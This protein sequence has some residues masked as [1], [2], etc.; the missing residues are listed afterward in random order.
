VGSWSPAAW[1]GWVRV[2]F[3][4]IVAQVID[5]NGAGI[6]PSSHPRQITTEIIQGGADLVE[7]RADLAADL[8]IRVVSKNF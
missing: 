4:R 1:S 8:L 6:T 3:D 2:G 5:Q 7:F